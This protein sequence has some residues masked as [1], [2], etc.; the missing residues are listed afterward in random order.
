VSLLKIGSVVD[1]R[2]AVAREILSSELDYTRTLEAIRKV[3][4]VPCE[5]A[6]S[7]N[8]AIISAPNLQLIFN[9]I[10]LL[11]DLSR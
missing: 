4:Y 8:R 9:D 3:F 6:L 10:L 5:A 7:A 11:A 2:E 1:R